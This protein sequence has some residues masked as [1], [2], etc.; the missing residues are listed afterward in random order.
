MAPRGTLSPGDSATTSLRWG[1][2]GRAKR[3]PDK[4]AAMAPPLTRACLRRIAQFFIRTQ[5]RCNRSPGASVVFQG[6]DHVL[7]PPS[8]MSATRES[9]ATRVRGFRFHWGTYRRLED[10]GSGRS[11]S[12][13][14]DY[15]LRRPR[16]PTP[17]AFASRWTWEAATDECRLKAEAKPARGIKCW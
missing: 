4:G 12:P 17:G 8:S 1:E 7:E 13:E 10:I 15:C 6:A 5:G 14:P 3:R 2:V 16:R 9:P 11:P